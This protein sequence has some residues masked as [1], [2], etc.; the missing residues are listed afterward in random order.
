MASLLSLTILAPAWLGFAPAASAWVQRRRPAVPRTATAPARNSD[1][2]VARIADEYLRGHYAFNPTEATS[3]GL[4]EFDAQLETR[5]AD[6]VAR[7]ARRL[8]GAL[9]DLGRVA[10]WRLSP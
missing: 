9:A 10:E 5:S 8:R 4:H 6:A 1:A 3:A 2:R 7:E